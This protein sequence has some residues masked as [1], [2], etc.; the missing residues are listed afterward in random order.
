MYRFA[1]S[2]QYIQM[3]IL[4]V[5]NEKII[6][7][8]LKKSLEAE[9][10]VVDT[11]EN[12]ERGFYLAR[13]NEHDVVILD[14]ILPKKTG[15]EICRELRL[16]SIHTPILILSIRS[17]IA[18][19]TELL[20]A[21]AD[22]YLVKPFSLE[23]LLAR[24]RALLRRPKIIQSETLQID[25]I[26]VD[27]KKHTVRRGKKEIYLTRKEFML[28]EYLLRNK[29]IPVS[30][31]MIMEHVWDMRVDPFSNT[32]ESHILSLRKKVDLSGKKKA[33]HTIPGIGYKI[34]LKNC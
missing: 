11:A 15:L 14:D 9:S 29:D 17:E 6:R 20:D 23:E 7:D 26:I 13:T 25:D 4:V 27:T 33:I 21:G 8:F 31:G 5:E 24:L 16:S 1:I 10:F 2:L 19:K 34:G 12:G 32:I 18:T 3:K 22:D 30:R 28:L